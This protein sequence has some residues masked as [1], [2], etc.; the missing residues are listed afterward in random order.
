MNESIALYVS[1]TLI[2]LA[3]M[4][5]IG[6]LLSHSGGRGVEAGKKTLIWLL[7]L[8]LLY[9]LRDMFAILFLT[10][11]LSFV[12][13]TIIVHSSRRLPIPHR[14]HVVA[15]YLL[16]VGVFY[17][18]G[19][20]L[21]PHVRHEGG[22]F[23]EL[24]AAL[25][26]P[27]IDAEIDAFLAE[28]PELVMAAESL[29]LREEV[30]EFLLTQREGFVDAGGR[31][32]RGVVKAA[33]GFLISLVFSF[34]IMLDL[35]AMKAW[36]RTMKDTRLGAI[37]EETADTVV[38][39]A[40]VL[41][42]VFQAQTVIAMFNTAL[43]LVG[44]VILGVP[45]LT[46]LALVVFLCSFVP[47]VG[48]FVS[49]VPIGL[50]ALRTGGVSKL[51]LVVLWIVVIHIVEAYILN[52]RIMA[53]KMKLNPVLVLVI[54]VVS[55]HYFGLWGVL[56]GVPVAFYVLKFALPGRSFVLLTPGTGADAPPT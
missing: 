10:F 49:S 23:V 9:S 52:P 35:E 1:L 18:I 41:G 26:G 53:V 5:L 32:L 50:L 34:L 19:A 15:T 13:N 12:A 51:F 11:V 42:Q 56:L 28:R 29:R 46:F 36:I 22:A 45:S 31:L 21:L 17:G 38:Q 54:L 43:T 2:G 30:R 55:H 14:W 16:L 24:V 33:A 39:F 3:A 40:G 20:F 37:Y 8:T 27:R 7:F 48:V 25:D 6:F 4:G 47:V 44:L